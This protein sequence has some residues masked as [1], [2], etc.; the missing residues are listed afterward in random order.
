MKS[1]MTLFQCA[2]F[3]ICMIFFLSAGP[4]SALVKQGHQVA[5]FSF[6]D[7]R[8]R[9]IQSK[10][11]LKTP[12]T[13]VFFFLPEIESDR[14]ILKSIEYLAKKEQALSVI[15]VPCSQREN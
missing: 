11:V 15:A 6:E 4:A 1:I 2:I 12:L 8:G 14:Q 5:P 13:D 9:T 10:D 7:M 3:C